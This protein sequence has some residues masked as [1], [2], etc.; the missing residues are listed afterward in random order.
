MVMVP[1]LMAEAVAWCFAGDGD[2]G[3][4][5]GLGQA[6]Q[7]SVYGGHVQRGDGRLSGLEKPL[8]AVA[9]LRQ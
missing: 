3:D 8:G 9:T 4:L 5:A 6:L 7:R 1:L 2:G